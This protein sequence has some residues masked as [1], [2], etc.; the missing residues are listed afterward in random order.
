MIGSNSRSGLY[1]TALFFLLAPACSSSSENVPLGSTGGRGSSTTT[2][3]SSQGG[4]GDGSGVG[5][6]TSTG[7]GGGG[8]APTCPSPVTPDPLAAKRAACAFDQGAM[9]TD[10]IGIS[11]QD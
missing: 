7:A 6:T 3:A 1:L 5:T 9:P 11:K 4:G 10:T 8:G 2:T